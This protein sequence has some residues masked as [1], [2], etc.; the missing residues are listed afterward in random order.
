MIKKDEEDFESHIKCWIRD[1][2]YVDGDAKVRAHCHIT[3]KY[4][5][6]AHKDCNIKVKLNHRTYI[7]FHNLRNYDSHLIMQELGK[8][9]FKIKMIP[10]GLEKYVNFNINNKLIFLDSF[11]FLRFSL[12][13]LI[14]IL[15]K[16][17]F[18]YLS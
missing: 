15:G 14:K 18:R 9:D 12:D 2:D 4:K 7:T 1:N 8:F 3:Q 10:N 6:S 5:D 13:S 17:D 11:E 16:E